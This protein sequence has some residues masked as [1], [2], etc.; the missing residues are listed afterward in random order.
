MLQNP[1]VELIEAS[2]EWL[3][4][5]LVFYT[6]GDDR[7]ISRGKHGY[8]GFSNKP[9]TRTSVAKENQ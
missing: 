1:P 5:H 7:S 3:R 4:K 9:H 2:L 8:Y 6:F